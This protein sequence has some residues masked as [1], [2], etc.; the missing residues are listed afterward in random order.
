MDV[1]RLLLLTAAACLLLAGCA[2]G[3]QHARSAPGGASR[4]TTAAVGTTSMHTFR[5]FDANGTPTAPVSSHT[6]GYCWETSL[7][8]PAAGSYRCLAANTILD[9]CFA[10]QTATTP[11]QH[12]AARTLACFSSPWSKAVVLTVHRRLPSSGAELDRPWAVVLAGGAHCVA[13]T[14]TA[15]FVAGVGLDY[16]CDDGT[17][18]ALRGAGTQVHALVGRP[19]AHS[20]R[21]VTVTDV[22]RG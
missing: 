13:A 16:S 2:S 11:A 19:D 6:S 4:S 12:H 10:P 9:P 22:W 1:R 18:A 7:A 15:P 17:A 21:R 8:A 3:V 5:P 20:L 14:G